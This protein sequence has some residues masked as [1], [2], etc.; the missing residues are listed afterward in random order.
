[1]V[2]ASLAQALSRSR[3]SLE[4]LTINRVN[5]DDLDYYFDDD[6]DGSDDARSSDGVRFYWDLIDTPVMI[7]DAL[8]GGAPPSAA[9]PPLAVAPAL[10]RITELTLSGALD[11]DAAEAL[12]RCLSRGVRIQG[13]HIIAASRLGQCLVDGRIVAEVAEA[14]LTLGPAARLRRLTV[15]NVSNGLHGA[16]SAGNEI[17]RSSALSALIALDWC[18]V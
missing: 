8:G 18:C 14:L 10:P 1:M 12:G 4:A 9:A 11:P 15:S 16:R 6:S 17:M 13:L 3:V 5:F 2:S 7:L